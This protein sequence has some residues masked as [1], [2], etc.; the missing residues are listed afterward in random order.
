MI[1]VQFDFFG[2]WIVGIGKSDFL[3][4]QYRHHSISQ[5]VL[6]LFVKRSHF[7]KS[8]GFELFMLRHQ[9][10]QLGPIVNFHSGAQ[11]VGDE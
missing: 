6:L 4:E 11:D 8:F 9:L 5:I 2:P 7:L 1:F 10:N 3:S